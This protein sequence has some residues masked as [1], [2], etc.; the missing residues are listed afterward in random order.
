MFD[1]LCI[2][3][4]MALA[5]Q[6][7]YALEHDDNYGGEGLVQSIQT[8]LEASSGNLRR[9]LINHHSNNDAGVFDACHLVSQHF[10]NDFLSNKSH[11]HHKKNHHVGSGGCNCDGNLNG[12]LTL[13]CDFK[14]VCD[15]VLCASVNV[16]VTLTDVLDD[17]GRFGND[18]KMNLAS[19]VDTDQ[20]F[21]ETMCLDMDFAKPDFFLPSAC[22]F[23]YGDKQCICEVIDDDSSPFGVPC[24][25]FDCSQVAFDIPTDQETPTD[26]SMARLLK[27]DNCKAVDLSRKND[28]SILLPALS[29]SVVQSD[30]FEDEKKK[31]NAE[32]HHTADGVLSPI[33]KKF[34][35][36]AEKGEKHDGN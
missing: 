28:A 16:S 13:H 19:C 24:Y 26:T 6:P 15:S 10:G 34:A 17:N 21:L 20:D 36:W 32:F 18:P 29:K 4:F 12:E 33:E 1:K 23:S 14:D 9:N 5:V 35:V 2:V 31:M 8:R 30:L 11:H 22:S 25:K 27:S 3:T 7:G